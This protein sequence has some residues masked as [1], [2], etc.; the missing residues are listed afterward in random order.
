MLLSEEAS[1]AAC[2]LIQV[3][4][5]LAIAVD[6]SRLFRVPPKRG[7]TQLSSS[8]LK[9]TYLIVLCAGYVFVF[10]KVMNV[11]LR[12][13]CVLRS[14]CRSALEAVFN[15]GGKKDGVDDQVLDVAQAMLS[16]LLH[17]CEFRIALRL[18]ETLFGDP[19]KRATRLSLVS[20]PTAALYSYKDSRANPLLTNVFRDLGIRMIE[21]LS[22]HPETQSIL[23]YTV[24]GP[25]KLAGECVVWI[26]IF[27]ACIM[28]LPRYPYEERAKTSSPKKPRLTQDALQRAHRGMPA[29]P[30]T[31][32]TT[33]SSSSGAPQHH[34][35]K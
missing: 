4:L 34:T 28:I 26:C 29:F 2:E 16:S 22:T 32:T 31:E 8:S 18:L 12:D 7:D 17:F 20:I 30:L 13:G 3:V 10:D 23:A 15:I 9:L 24:E 5:F 6:V 21:H 1:G 25:A 14:M 35:K 11:L 33:S 27:V 19:A